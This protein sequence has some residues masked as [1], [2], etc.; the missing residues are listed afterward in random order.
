MICGRIAIATDNTVHQGAAIKLHVLCGEPV[1]SP[2][3]HVW[4]PCQNL[5]LQEVGLYT[6]HVGFKICTSDW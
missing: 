2:A 4:E 1:P 6:T 3:A 5:R